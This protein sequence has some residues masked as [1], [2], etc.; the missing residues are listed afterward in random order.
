M[1]H[2]WR[3]DYDK[4]GDGSFYWKRVCETADA[5]FYLLGEK[6]YYK[7]IFL[8]SEMKTPGFYDSFG[9]VLID[10][11]ATSIKDRFFWRLWN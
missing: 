7:K 1:L 9:F 11:L 8:D 3:K 5:W 2:K 6:Q 4:F 10:A